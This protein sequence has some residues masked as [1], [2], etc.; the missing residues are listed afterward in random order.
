MLCESG[1]T[2]QWIFQDKMCKTRGTSPSLGVEAV[3][4]LKSFLSQWWELS[5]LLRPCVLLH[6]HAVPSW[7]HCLP[8]APSA[9]DWCLLGREKALTTAW[10]VR[11]QQC[12]LS[13]LLLRGACESMFARRGLCTWWDPGHSEGWGLERSHFRPWILARSWFQAPDASFALQVMIYCSGF[14]S[15]CR[16]LRK[17]GRNVK[18]E[19]FSV[20]SCKILWSL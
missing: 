6:T 7:G 9:R 2:L 3:A 4:L 10:P 11:D 12:I 1:D 19:A 20:L 17:V 18:M 16:S 5:V 15:A 8:Q 14:S 13:P